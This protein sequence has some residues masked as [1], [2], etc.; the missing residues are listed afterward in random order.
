M[1]SNTTL[2]RRSLLASVPVVAALALPTAATALSS[3]AT[4]A[5]DD[6]IFAI[7]QAHLQ[8]MQNTTAAYH[9]QNDVEKAGHHLQD[10]EFMAANAIVHEAQDEQEDALYAFLTTPPKTVAG[11]VAALNHAS[12]PVF[13]HER[14]QGVEHDPS[15]TIILDTVS[16]GDASLDAAAKFPA[17]IADALRD[18][19]AA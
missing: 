18:L 19:I 7:I 11:I 8:A 9:A 14:K 4:G 3:D 1:K 6:P 2:S 17:M 16:T 13:P 5:E 10:P 12:S 15:E